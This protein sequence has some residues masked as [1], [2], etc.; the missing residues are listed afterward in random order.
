MILHK[1]GPRRFKQLAKQLKIRILSQTS[2]LVIYLIR[3]ASV[4]MPPPPFKEG[5]AYCFAHV[6]RYPLTLCN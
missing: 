6:G 4:I 1:A 5:G 2:I 3:H